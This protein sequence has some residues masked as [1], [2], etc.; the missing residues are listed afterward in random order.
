MDRFLVLHV[1]SVLLGI[2]LVGVA[3]G[4]ALAGVWLV[5]R[6]T[7]I[8]SLRSHNDVAGFII[9]VVG[10]IYGVLLAFVVIVVWERFDEAI[11]VADREAD[12]VL[13]LYRD[14]AAF[15]DQTAELRTRIRGYASSV[16]EQEWPTMAS[17]Q[18]DD[19]ETDAAMESLFA[20]YRSVQLSSPQQ[21]PFRDASIQR[22]DDIAEA[23][24]AR[25]L[26]SSSRLP[27]PMWVLVLAGGAI[28]VA[29]T[30]FF[31]V[32]NARAHFLM[33][34]AVAA[35]IALTLFLILSLGFPFSGDVAVGPSAMRDAIREFAHL[36]G[37]R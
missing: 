23:R 18:G 22:L 31:A 24:R 19:E 3:V 28:T 10:V 29:F 8:E 7:D 9:A 11:G 33:V 4:A 21:D 15:P 12:L 37:G 25:I 5:R 27:G 20:A 17:S 34:G 14:A 6:R 1:P 35:M 32:S 26:A 36:D 13:A 2:L 30:Y 16:V